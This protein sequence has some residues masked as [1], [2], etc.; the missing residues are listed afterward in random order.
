MRPIDSVGQPEF[1]QSAF[2]IGLNGLRNNQSFSMFPYIFPIARG[3]SG[4][5][6]D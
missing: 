4:S 2:S 1:R 3:L 5:L 6:A